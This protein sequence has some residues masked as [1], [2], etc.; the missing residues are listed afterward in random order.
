[1]TVDGVNMDPS[2]KGV[3]FLYSENCH[4]FADKPRISTSLAAGRLFI[5]D[6][7]R[8]YALAQ[9]SPPILLSVD[10]STRLNKHSVRE[11][12]RDNR[13]GAIALE[14]YRSAR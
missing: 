10:E 6:T 14:T 1:M 7:K 8:G 4:Y 12:A 11:T 3:S 9:L 13:A 2:T 5:E